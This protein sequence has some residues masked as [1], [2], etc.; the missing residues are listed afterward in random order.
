MRVP[1]RRED[2]DKWFQ[3]AYILTKCFGSAISTIN[4]TFPL[5][6]N[7]SYFD[8]ADFMKSFCPTLFSFHLMV[9]LRVRRRMQN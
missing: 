1:Q 2:P 8:I 7:D 9:S 3:L 4:L 5:N 6:K